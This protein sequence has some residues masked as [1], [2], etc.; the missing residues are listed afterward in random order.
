M[1]AKNVDFNKAFGVP[2]GTMRLLRM[3][4]SKAGKTCPATTEPCVKGRRHLPQVMHYTT[5]P[6]LSIPAYMAAFPAYKAMNVR[7]LIAA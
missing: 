4:S 3:Y 7:P 2:V 5:A 1:T 6:A